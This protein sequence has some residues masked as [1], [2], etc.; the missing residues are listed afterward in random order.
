MLT[1][2]PL[3][4][5]IKQH[6]IGN[7]YPINL[8]DELIKESDDFGITILA[9][10]KNGNKEEK[11]NKVRIKRI[12]RLGKLNPFELFKETI[13]LRPNFF[14]IQYVLGAKYG[15]GLH[16][17]SP[18]VLMLLLRIARRPLII[19]IHDIIPMNKITSTFKKMFKEK[20]SILCF[21]YDIGY[22]ITTMY[23][24]KIA[25]KIIVLD[26]GTKKWAIDQ[27]GYS[28]NKIKLIPHGMLN[29]SD[30]ITL[31]EAKKALNINEKWKVLLFFGKIHP[32]KGIEYAIKALSYV[33]KSHPKTKL[34][35]AGS[36]SKMWA[37][38]VRSYIK[39]LKK[40][41][42]NLGLE[43]HVSFNIKYFGEEI[44]IIFGAADIV[45]LPYVVPY[46]ASGVLKLAATYNK[47]VITT[48][49]LSRKGEITNGISG[50]LL[51]S[52]D[53]KIFA[54]KINQL[55]DDKPL[56]QKI[57][58]RFYEQ[59]IITSKWKKVAK[60]TIDFYRGV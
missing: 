54:Q 10:K 46:G 6:K 34:L 3:E 51:S 23:M 39:D 57:G 60:E 40:M 21:I 8:I 52:L 25:S 55:F 26:E 35:I 14:H 19:T 37:K 44:P 56:S 41:V 15:K 4:N 58:E 47:P 33:L 53:E 36:Y 24:G 30:I 11:Y 32:R 13:K 18:F 28:K 16:L 27:Y 2:F 22:R 49:S 1:P 45:V 42:K 50:I 59:N 38:E 12:W 48:C 9:D 43:N 31:N 7:G 29:S 5:E 20:N 17:I